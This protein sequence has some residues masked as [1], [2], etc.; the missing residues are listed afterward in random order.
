MTSPTAMGAGGGDER[1]TMNAHD[2]TIFFDSHG[3]A[4]LA[5]PWTN[6]SL[7]DPRAVPCGPSRISRP[8][9]DEELEN[10]G[11]LD[12]EKTP[13]SMAAGRRRTEGEWDVLVPSTGGM[14]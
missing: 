1:R 12:G 3:Q 2:L 5:L 9:T 7:N 13:W 14:D 11:L 4:H 10:H 6:E 8:L